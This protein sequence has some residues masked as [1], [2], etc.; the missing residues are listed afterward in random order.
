MLVIDASVGLAL[1][2]NQK[3]ISENIRHRLEEVKQ[4]YVPHLF[5]IEII[6][7]LR[8]LNISQEI[9]DEYTARAI[10]LLQQIRLV[11]YPDYIFI[12][13]I[14]E[15]RHS[16]SAY[17]AVYIAMAEALGSTLVTLDKR[18]AR[19]RGHTASIELLA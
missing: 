18:L 9:S 14:W 10:D 4:L 7:V 6:H 17:D 12:N 1:I 13:R 15:L 11:H 19:A 3:P 2:L 5:E 8:R 16:I